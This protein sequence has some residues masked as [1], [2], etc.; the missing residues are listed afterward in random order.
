MAAGMDATAYGLVRE[1]EYVEQWFTKLCE[2]QGCACT[3]FGHSALKTKRKVFTQNGNGQ[4][5]GC[6][7][8]TEPDSGS[9]PGS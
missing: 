2:C 4:L 6:F 3:P 5:I 7:G 8:L 1:L 9:D